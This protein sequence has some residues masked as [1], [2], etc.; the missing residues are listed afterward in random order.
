MKE[1]NKGWNWKKIVIKRMRI[2]LDTKIKLNKIFWDKIEKKSIEKSIKSKTNSNL[3]KKNRNW[4]KYKLEDTF[5]FWKS[6][7]KIQ[8][9][10]REKRE[11]NN[12]RCSQTVAP[13]CTMKRTAWY[14]QHRRK[15]WRLSDK[16]CACVTKRAWAPHASYF[17]LIILI[18]I[19]RL[20]CSHSH[21]L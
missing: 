21:Y 1:N 4:Y 3:K 13:S 12:V 8:C 18:F 19:K 2:K 17:F 16:K 5:N 15:K 20:T 11:E 10:Q 14:F 7:R 9:E 6:Q